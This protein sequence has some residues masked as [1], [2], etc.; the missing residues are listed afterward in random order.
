MADYVVSQLTLLDGRTVEI[1]DAVARAAIQGGTYFLGITTTAL[2]DGASTNPIMI[3]GVS[4]TATNGNQVIYENKE[5]VFAAYD[6]KWH[7]L[8]DLTGLGDL[9]LKDNASGT[10]TPTGTVNFTG[11]V[12]NV[13][14]PYTPAG[15]I[16]K[17]VI[18]VTTTTTNI[19]QIDNTGSVTAG[20]AASAVLP[21]W[22][23]IVVGENLTFSWNQGSFTPNT[24]TAVSLP[25]SKTTAV[26]T[27]ASAELR[28]AP[29]FTGT[30]S[31]I[32]LEGATSG[33]ATFVGTPATI[34]VS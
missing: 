14:G 13:T 9:A 15:T 28:S 26:V 17:P 7:E 10:Y 8:G 21:A 27:S 22:N 33:T 29:E 19:K 24:P 12:I 18:D 16:D 4:T 3:G 20:V 31:T 30:A 11:N 25:T 6:S 23:A 34:T 2:V 1:K 5:F 32:A